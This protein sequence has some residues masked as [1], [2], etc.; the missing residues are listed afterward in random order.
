MNDF[1]ESAQDVKRYIFSDVA[2]D[3]ATGIW[4]IFGIVFNNFACMDSMLDF[5]HGNISRV[6][7]PLRMFCNYVFAS[8]QLLAYLL[9]HQLFYTIKVK[10]CQEI[11]V[12]VV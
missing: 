10:R 7:T 1:S 12:C 11:Y 9:Q 8:Q 2:K 5:F 6:A 3:K 4:F